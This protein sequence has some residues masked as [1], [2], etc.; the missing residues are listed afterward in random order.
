MQ[1]NFMKHYVSSLSLHTNS[2]YYS[3]LIYF[4][5]IY[6]DFMQVQ[7]KIVINVIKINAEEMSCQ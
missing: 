6:Y 7:H 4:N 5:N 3:L 2:L 1:K